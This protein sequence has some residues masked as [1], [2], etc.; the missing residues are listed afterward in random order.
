MTFHVL[1]PGSEAITSTAWVPEAR[2]PHE[3]PGP[4]GCA[5][6]GLGGSA[7]L[8]RKS[9][10]TV[11]SEL[12]GL[13]AF[14]KA[15]ISLT[16]CVSVSTG[17]RTAGVPAPFQGLRFAPPARVHH[18]AAAEEAVPAVRVPAGQ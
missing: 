11:C 1:S 9:V 16:S 3:Q 10:D 18:A 8:Q 14:L 17:R 5:P 15:A 6:A 13:T 7:R 12:L 4:G 2:V